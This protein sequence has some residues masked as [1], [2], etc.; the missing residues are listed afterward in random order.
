MADQRDVSFDDVED[1]L[2]ASFSQDENH[3]SSVK[4]IMSMI[5]DLQVETNRNQTVLVKISTGI[6]TITDFQR[7]FQTEVRASLDNL[8]KIMDNVDQGL[9]A[10]DETKETTKKQGKPQKEKTVPT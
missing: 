9:K 3:A 8:T 5:T 7:A 4:L 2:S 1:L 6:T 10:K